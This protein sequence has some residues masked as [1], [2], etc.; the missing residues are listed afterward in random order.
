MYFENSDYAAAA[1]LATIQAIDPTLSFSD[2][3]EIGA[4]CVGTPTVKNGITYTILAS[5]GEYWLSTRIE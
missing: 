2:A 1:A 5:N 4:A 3:K